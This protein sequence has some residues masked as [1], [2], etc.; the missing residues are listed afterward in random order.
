MNTNRWLK[1]YVYLRVTPKGKKPGFR[2][3]MSTFG[4]SGKSTIIII[5]VAVRDR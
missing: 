1:N 2:S 4:T 3:S 5:D